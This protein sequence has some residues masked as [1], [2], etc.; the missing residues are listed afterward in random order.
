VEVVPYDPD[1]PQVCA[2]EAEIVARVL[3]DALLAAHHVGSTAVVGMA[4]KPTVD[5]L[6]VV[7]DINAVDAAGE[8]F[9]AAGYQPRGELG[10]PG[11]RYFVKGTR[12]VHVC[13]VH[14]FQA[15]HPEIERHRLL[16]AYLARH[17]DDAERY[18]RAKESLARRHRYDSEA[19]TGGKGPLIRELDALARR[20][21]LALE[22]MGLDEP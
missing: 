8:R 3:G 22:S 9:V 17:P 18:A 13:H 12:V 20:W 2:R 1:W 14:A 15:G 7:E 11:R 5:I 4:A 10:I 16:I 19:Y 21:W 6:V